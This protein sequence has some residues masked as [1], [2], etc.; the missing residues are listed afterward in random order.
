MC[1]KTADGGRKL[2]EARLLILPKQETIYAFQ[3]EQFQFPWNLK[4]ILG[5]PNT[6]QSKHGFLLF[7][8]ASEHRKSMDACGFFA[9]LQE[10][11]PERGPEQ[12]VFSRLQQVN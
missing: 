6:Q 2:Q 1:E 12:S 9:S 5:Q 8:K 11:S 7:F 4:L 10:K 3:P